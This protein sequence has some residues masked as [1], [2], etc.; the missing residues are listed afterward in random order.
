MSMKRIAK[1]EVLRH[2]PR[3]GQ[4]SEPPLR[5]RSRG[6]ET[7]PLDGS[8]TSH[9]RVARREAVALVPH[10]HDFRRPVNLDTKCLTVNRSLTGRWF[11][12]A[13]IGRLALWEQP[14]P[15]HGDHGLVSA[16]FRHGLA[17]GMRPHTTHGLDSSGP[18]GRRIVYETVYGHRNSSITPCKRISCT[19]CAASGAD[20][21][22]ARRPRY[23]TRRCSHARRL[24]GPLLFMSI[25]RRRYSERRT[26]IGGIRVARRAGT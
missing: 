10:L 5:R 25:H 22:A 4:L 17:H 2:S 18:S 13:V 9:P 1:A 16:G 14:L 21:A 19:S 6:G 11:R 3:E 8:R 26:S 24:V 20:A 12:L 7:V 15:Q 23:G